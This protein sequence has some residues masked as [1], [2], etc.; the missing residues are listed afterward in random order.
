MKKL[1]QFFFQKY[2]RCNGKIIDRFQNKNQ[3]KISEMQ[4]KIDVE[5]ET[6]VYV[7]KCFN[8]IYPSSIE[9]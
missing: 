8:L 9:Q 3:L 4:K 6:L 1:C 5:E 7:Y 2:D